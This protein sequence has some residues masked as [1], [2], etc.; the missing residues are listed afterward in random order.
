M[1]APVGASRPNIAGIDTNL[2]VALD[3]L[4]RERNVTRAAKRLGLGQSATSHALARLRA[5][6]EDALLVRAG[7]ELVLTERGR[8]LAGPAADAV[9]TL[10][11]VFAPPEAFD[12]KK[13]T[14]AFRIAATDNV[15]LYVLP[16]LARILA[17]EA[18]HVDLRFHHLPKD[19][20]DALARSDFELKLGRKPRVEAPLKN[21]DLFR[22]RIVCVVR[23]RH[24]V[25]KRM[26][27]ARYASLSHVLVAPGESGRGV[28]DDVLARQGLERRV[29][30]TLP[31][32][33]VALHLVAA[34][35]HAITVPARLVA[36]AA[37]ALRLRAI[38][39]P[40]HVNAYTLSQVWHER[41]END[42][43]HRWL[44]G[45]IHR[46]I[47]NGTAQHAPNDVIDG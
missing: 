8:A 19:W 16:R 9:A 44:R 22:D 4:L 17:R 12:P 3:A 39:L 26:S 27:V 7:R 47:G 20:P 35:D 18:P 41:H 15:E 43:G 13:S 31:H 46:A 28:I 6:F 37:P 10:E 5:H 33:L 34:S 40:V 29:A 2:V 1:S 24:P 14:R 38:P 25:G 36:A 45:V 30:V 23:E 32:F 21:Q 42:E 11:R